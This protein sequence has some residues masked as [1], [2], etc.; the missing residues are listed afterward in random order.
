MEIHLERPLLSV[1]AHEAANGGPVYR[2][3]PDRCCQQRKVE[4]LHRVTRRFDAWA[5]GIRR[6]QSPTRAN[7]ECGLH[8]GGTRLEP[9]VGILRSAFRLAFFRTFC[10]RESGGGAVFH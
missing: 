9:P 4:V 6:D 2:T 5:S 1:P 3:D 8:T 7:T 10:Y